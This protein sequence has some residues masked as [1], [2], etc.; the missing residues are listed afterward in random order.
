MSKVT[1]QPLGIDQAAAAREPGIVVERLTSFIA[2]TGYRAI[3]GAVIAR[4][5]CSILD[6]LGCAIYGAGIDTTVPFVR[7]AAA[8]GG[9]PQSSIWGGGPATTAFYAALINATFIHATE[10]SETYIRAVVHPGNVIIPAVLAVGEREHSSGEDVL[11][12]TALAYEALIRFG[13]SVGRPFMIE[14]GLHSFSVMGVFGATIATSKVMRANRTT[15]DN[16]LGIAACQTATPL[17]VAAAEGAMIKEI[18]EG[19]ASALGVMSSDLA[20]NGVVG[21]KDWARAW[22]GAIPRVSDISRLGQGLGTTWLVAEPGL[23]IKM[24]PVM[25]MVQ[26]TVEALYDLIA[27]RPIDYGKI[28]RITVETSKRAF[29]A[30]NRQPDSMT[31][32]RVSI[33]FMTA[34]VL[35]RQASVLRDPYLIRFI[36]PELLSDAEV[37]NL[38]RKVDVTLDPVMEYNFEEA[39]QMKYE[40]RVRIRMQGGEEIVAYKDIW[41]ATSA[42]SYEQVAGKFRA[43]V[44]DSISESRATE[45]VETVRHLEQLGDVAELVRLLTRR[46]E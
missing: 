22:Y 31:A 5:K 36:Q 19:Y 10:I 6:A 7:Y 25:G 9:S 21:V 3:P 46:D 30:G 35:V 28:D 41:P 1:N 12:A 38:A 18:F 20:R 40:S 14:Q 4:T 17:I 45:I 43:C 2:D 26:P 33:P 11:T 39:P 42:M 24:R 34:A 37:A 32:A 16:A 44:A 8:Q 15:L 23:R 13:F 29:I 27:A